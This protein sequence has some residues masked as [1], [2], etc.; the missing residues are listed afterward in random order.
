MEL[1]LD[2]NETD[3]PS[4]VGEAAHI[5]AESPDGPR[6][7]SPIPIGQRN[8]Y[9]NLML[10]CNV[11]H[12]QVDDQV[13][14]FTVEAL[15]EAKTQHEDWVRSSLN[16]FNQQKQAE[17]ERWAGYVDEWAKR[18]Q[19][20]NWNNQV[21]CLLQADPGIS[22]SLLQDLIEVPRW[23]LS[24]V[25]P[26]SYPEL[27]AAFQNFQMVVSDLTNEFQKH[28]ETINPEY[29]FTKKF[30]KTEHYSEDVYHRLGRMYDFH[31]DLVEDLAYEMTRA[32][33]FVCDRVRG[34]LDSSFRIEE[35]VLLV[36]L[37]MDINLKEV[38]RRVEY[39]GSERVDRPYP[40]LT[41]FLAMRETRDYHQGSGTHPT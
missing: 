33:N 19:L 24:R 17:D 10:L 34:T 25:W 2:A 27:R 3:D 15:R 41:E 35:G 11:H 16:G 36:T 18:V 40:G 1:V 28:M 22:T 5:I 4:L 21:S 29:R 12:K 32:A 23:I 13:N 37:G 31:V 39:R 14:K 38:T 30:Y 20:G 6:G 7:N 9:L 8:S 26:E